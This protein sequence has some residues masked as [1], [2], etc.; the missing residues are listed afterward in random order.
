MIDGGWRAPDDWFLGA[1]LAD[2]PVGIPFATAQDLSALAA[3]RSAERGVYADQHSARSPRLAALTNPY[4]GAHY[5]YFAAHA[6]WR[7]D[8]GAAGSEA[9]CRW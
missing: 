6:V 5:M 4:D 2:R 3:V 8:A 9:V 1:R 7:Y